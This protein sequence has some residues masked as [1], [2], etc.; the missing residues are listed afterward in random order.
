MKLTLKYEEAD[1][2][3]QWMTLRL[4]LPL[5][6]VNGPTADV[7]KLFV[8]HYNKKHTERPLRG[9]ELHL[10]IVGG[11]HLA[12]DVCVRDRL[13][14]GYECYIMGETS[15]KKPRAA[16]TTLKSTAQKAV[17]PPPAPAATKVSCQDKGK[18]RCKRFGCQQFFDP[19]GPEQKCVHHKAPPIFHETAKWWSCCQDKKAYD[20]EEFMRIPGC[21]TGVCSASAEGQQKRFL[22]GT[23]LRADSAPVRLDE[24]AP[25]DPRHKLDDLRRGLV[26]VGVDGA[27]FEKV[28]TKF[29]AESGDLE[30]VCDLFKARFAGLLR[31]ADV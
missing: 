14:N 16:E 21:Q 19:E 11:D 6:Y 10:K 1:E 13:Q 29:A 20:W 2:Q 12:Q 23:D 31:T 30:K 7:V 28:W 9:E 24:D 27:L 18:A 3:E 5:K 26:A 22:G 4:T 8:D 25:R 15:S 17:A